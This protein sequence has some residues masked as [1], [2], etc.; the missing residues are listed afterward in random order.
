MSSSI[1]FDRRR[2]FG[3][4]DDVTGRA[5][6]ASMARRSGTGEWGAPPPPGA[7]A[8]RFCL[9]SSTFAGDRK[10]GQSI[11]GPVERRFIDWAA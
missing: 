4:L 5:T 3:R 1:A 11:L 2:Y 10:H 7:V 6:A 8:L 9:V